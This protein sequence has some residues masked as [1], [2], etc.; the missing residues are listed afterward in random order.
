MKEIKKRELE[1]LA[2]ICCE[3]NTSL[4]LAKELIKSSEK[5]SYENVSQSSRINEY[6]ELIF[7]Y[8]QKK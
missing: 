4:K 8:S 1:L 6:Q 3:N 5:Y 2:K 7:Y